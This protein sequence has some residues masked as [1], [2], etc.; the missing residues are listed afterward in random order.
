[1]MTHLPPSFACS[2][3]YKKFVEAGNL[4]THFKTHAGIL[5]EVCKICSKAYSIKCVLKT[6]IIRQHFSKM[7]CEVPDCSYKTGSKSDFKRHLK[8]HHQYSDKNMIEHLLKDLEKLKPDFQKMK[9]V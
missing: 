9:Y 4:K 6:H 2:K 7:Y 8:K 1:M 5:N 3:C